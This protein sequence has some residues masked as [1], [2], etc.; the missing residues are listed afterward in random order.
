M[1]KIRLSR[2]RNNH[3]RV[4]PTIPGARIYKPQNLSPPPSPVNNAFNREVFEIKVKLANAEQKISLLVKDYNKFI[5]DVNDSEGGK[6]ID[7]GE[8]TIDDIINHSPV[9]TSEEITSLDDG[10]KEIYNDIQQDIINAKK[11]WAYLQT[12][13]D[14]HNTN[15]VLPP[16]P[17]GEKP[18]PPPPPNIGSGSG[19]RTK[20]RKR[21]QKSKKEKSKKEKSKKGKAKKQRKTN[22][23]KQRKRLNK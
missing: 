11:I 16:S 5:I 1:P 19:I 17:L 8:L 14:A 22:Y 21:K 20:K 13:L 3:K 10:K 2:I 23:K 4:T 18:F 12:Q 15:M 7:I 6:K 9:L